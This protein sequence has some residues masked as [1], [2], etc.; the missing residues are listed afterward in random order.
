MGGVRDSVQAEGK[1]TRHLSGVVDR[2]TYVN[3]ETGYTVARLQPADDKRIV[4]VVGSLPSVNVGESV[5]LSGR[6]EKHALHGWQFVAEGCRVVL[7]ATVEGIRRYLGSGMIKG[8]GPK[9]A[10]RIVDR[11]GDETLAVIDEDPERLA[12]V[13]GL[14]PHRVNLIRDAWREQ[15]AIKEVMVFLAEEGVSTALA[16]R[17]YKRY[18]DAAI[19]IVKNDPYRLA[20]E[21][22][23]IGFK[24]ADKIAANLGIPPD[25]L[26][27]AMGAAL[28]LLWEAADD[29]HVYLPEEELVRRGV[30]MLAVDEARVRDAVERLLGTDNARRERV[31]ERDVIY[32]TPYYHAEGG[33]VRRLAALLRSPNDSLAYFKEVDFSRAFAWY[34]A[35]RTSSSSGR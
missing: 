2:L 34:T 14:G 15:R 30:E 8:I 3:A 20:R 32:L 13:A 31:D 7:P 25:S 24:T 35:R 21:V 27:R 28:H 26:E 11:F 17:I 33:I 19:A 23:G 29:G 10:E 22:F 9:M 18:G 6:W 5:E 16:V 4:T 1:A 12:E